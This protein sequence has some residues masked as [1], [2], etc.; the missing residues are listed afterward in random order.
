MPRFQYPLGNGSKLYHP[1]DHQKLLQP[2]FEPFGLPPF[3]KTIQNAAKC[4]NRRI[5]GPGTYTIDRKRKHAFKYSFGHRRRAIPATR[6]LCTQKSTAICIDCHKQAKGD[7][8]QNW[9]SIEHEVICRPCMDADRQQANAFKSK[10]KGFKRLRYLKEFER[11]RYC[12]YCHEHNGTTAS[13][14]L[15]NTNDL[16]KKFRYENYMA[17]FEV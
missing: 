5:P 15:W 17:M 16:R 13:L 6:T 9:N 11:V 4:V 10:F 2:N 3:R 1:K 7:Y 8:W 14:K 12:G